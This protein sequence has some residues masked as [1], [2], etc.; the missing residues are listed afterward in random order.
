VVC[1]GAEFSGRVFA[2]GKDSQGRVVR[3]FACPRDK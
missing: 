3:R 2:Q 1:D